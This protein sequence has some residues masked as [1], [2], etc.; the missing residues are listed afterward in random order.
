MRRPILVLICAARV[1]AQSGQTPAFEA[2]SV[3]PFVEGTPIQYS[4]CD[5]GPGS[6]NPGQIHCQYVTLRMLLMRAYQVKNQE[7]FGPGWLDTAHFEI[8]AKLPAG[9]IKEQVGGMF[10]GLLAERFHVELHRET[11]PLSVYS[12]TVAKSGLKLKESS[13]RP[14][15]DEPGT[16]GPPSVG[17]DGFPVLRP[18]ILAA[19]PIVLYRGGRARLLGNKVKLARLAETLT[20]QLDH[21]VIDE[22]GL[23]RP[24]DITLTWTPDST[25]PGG[26]SRPALAEAGSDPGDV[27]LFQAMEQQLGLRLASAKAQRD[28]IVVDRAERV[29]VEN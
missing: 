9:A 5:G 6:D 23:D 12:L 3:K 22:T 11:R 26:H 15:V 16:P 28:V 7:I 24:Y 27:T 8:L 19:G 21:I 14:A 25:E 4:G 18:S 29:P 2:V 1:L 10:R 17:K 13:P 20:S